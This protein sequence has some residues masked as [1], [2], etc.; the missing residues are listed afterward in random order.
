MTLSKP[1]LKDL[2]SVPFIKD[3][4][5]LGSIAFLFSTV[6]NSLLSFW[7]LDY[8]GMVNYYGGYPE[9][10][11]RLTQKIAFAWNDYLFFLT[12][13]IVAILFC[14]FLSFLVSF[15]LRNKKDITL[16]QLKGL[17]PSHSEKEVF[18]GLEMAFCVS[19]LFAFFLSY[20][21]VFIINLYFGINIYYI[22]IGVNNYVWALVIILIFTALNAFLFLYKLS[23]KKLLKN[24]NEV[25]END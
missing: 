3:Y 25:L 15:Y 4:V 17:K 2:S 19:Y 24:I 20:L 6:I 23:R 5:L 14:F 21:W 9:F 11:R 22:Y 1:K 18:L 16:L 7:N 12:A 13:G 10:I 8:D